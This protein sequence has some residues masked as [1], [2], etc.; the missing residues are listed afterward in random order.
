[1]PGYFMSVSFGSITYKS[2]L[3]NGIDN[4]KIHP[5]SK[6]CELNN[7]ETVNFR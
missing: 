7:C 6:G 2:C 5:K 1:M 3:H 4:M